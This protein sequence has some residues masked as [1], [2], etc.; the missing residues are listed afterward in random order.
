MVTLGDYRHFKGDLYVVI[1][2]AKD[3][4]TEERMIVYTKESPIYWVR[5]EKNFE[6]EVEW[7]DGVRRPRF[8]REVPNVDVQPS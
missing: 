2:I 8:V 5:S 3:S 6:E 7:P 4:E 1:C